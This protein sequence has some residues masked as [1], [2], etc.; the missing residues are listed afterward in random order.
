[1]DLQSVLLWQHPTVPLHE[2]YYVSLFMTLIESF[3]LA[4]SVFRKTTRALEPITW[5]SYST[6]SFIHSGVGLFILIVC[7]LICEMIIL[8]YHPGLFQEG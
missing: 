5:T 7:F 1:M 6:L 3:I 2:Q 8:I 4:S